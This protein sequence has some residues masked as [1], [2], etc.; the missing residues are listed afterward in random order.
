MLLCLLL[1]ALCTLAEFESAVA[2]G[3]TRRNCTAPVESASSPSAL[4]STSESKA[5]SPS[6]Y[7]SAAIL[8]GLVVLVALLGI[9]SQ[10]NARS[11]SR[12]GDESA[13]LLG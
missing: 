1:A 10:R 2:F 4:L 11:K 13:T 3:R 8:L 6:Q 9:R 12:W 5:F 7:F